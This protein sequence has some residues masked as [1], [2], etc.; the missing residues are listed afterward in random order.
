MKSPI[1]QSS[2]S[3]TGVSSEIGSTMTPSAPCTMSTGICTRAAISAAA[4]SRPSSC[5]SW[6]EALISRLMRSI[7]CTGRRIVRA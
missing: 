1:A 5:T 3:P 7:M 6:R 2:S 4:G